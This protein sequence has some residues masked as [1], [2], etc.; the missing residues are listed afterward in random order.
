LGAPLT[1]GDWHYSAGTAVCWQ[2]QDSWLFS[3][4]RTAQANN[5]QTGAVVTA[6]QSVQQ[7]SRDGKT[8]GVF[9][10]ADIGV[11]DWVQF[12]ATPGE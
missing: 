9:A 7:R 8:L 10:N 3:P 2:D 6:G 4:T 5:R 12:D 1:L 11:I